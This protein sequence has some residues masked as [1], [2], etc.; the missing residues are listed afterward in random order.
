MTALLTVKNLLDGVAAGTITREAAIARCDEILA[1]TSVSDNKRARWTRVREGFAK[2]KPVTVA[3]AFTG[4]D[5][6]A[7][8]APAKAKAAKAAKAPAT[9][10]MTELARQMEALTAAFVALAKAK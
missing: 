1:R 6:P 2:A 4:M 7:K 8:K 5:A 10:P 9:D 3:A